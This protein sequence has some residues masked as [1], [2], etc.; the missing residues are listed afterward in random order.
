MT[1]KLSR[2]ARSRNMARIRGKDTSPEIKVRRLL[3]AIGYRYRLHVRRLPGSPDIAFPPRKRVIFLHGCFWH[4][5]SGCRHAN[6]P[7]SRTEYWEQKFTRNIER[8]AKNLRALIE[9]GWAVLVVWECETRSTEALTERLRDFL[10]PT[11]VKRLSESATAEDLRGVDTS[12]YPVLQA[13]LG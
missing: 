9:D 4:H 6:T 1:D 8:D 12:G 10:G 2:E 7:K 5:H 3:Y 13:V 11:S